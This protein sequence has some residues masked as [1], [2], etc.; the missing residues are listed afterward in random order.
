MA[1]AAGGVD[2][3]HPQRGNLQTHHP[4]RA[5]QVSAAEAVAESLL[6]STW[7]G[8]V[9]VR[10]ARDVCGMTGGGIK[11]MQD[12]QVSEVAAGRSRHKRGSAVSA[13][14]LC[15]DLPVR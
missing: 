12:K 5:R 6:N 13:C 15:G 11:A 2:C 10:C 14:V 8:K 7:R 4:P 1:T 3:T 9:D